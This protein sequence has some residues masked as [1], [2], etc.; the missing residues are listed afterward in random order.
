MTDIAKLGFEVDT[1]GLVRGKQATD[2]W[3]KSA[4][5]AKDTQ[6]KTAESTQELSAAF[7]KQQTLLQRQNILLTQGAEAAWKFD[8]EVEGL[9]AS[10][11]D[12]LEKLR[13]T[14]AEL[15]KGHEGTTGFA[16]ALGGLKGV[17]GAVGIAIASMGIDRV[18][19]FMVDSYRET[20]KMG[21]VLKTATG[22]VGLAAAELMKLRQYAADTPYTLAQ[23]VEGF[24]EL[25]NLG[26]DASIESM[27]SYGDTAS[28]LGKDYM[29]MVEAVADAATFQYDRLLEFGIKTQTEGDR[30]QFTFKGITTEVGKDSKAIEQYLIGLGK[31]EFSGAMSDQMDTLNG[32]ISN[33]QDA[34][35]EAANEFMVWSGAGEGLK[36][37]LGSLS[38]TMSGLTDAMRGARF[39][40]DAMSY[41][42]ADP[43]Q[44]NDIIGQVQAL[45]T[46]FKTA[47]DE[48]RVVIRAELL[49]FY[50]ELKARS[51]EYVTNITEE[52]KQLEWLP[53]MFSGA[54]A[55]M[56][57]ENGRKLAAT[58]TAINE[59][60]KAFRDTGTAITE[61]DEAQRPIWETMEAGAKRAAA[62]VA[63]V[64]AAYQ[65]GKA[66]WL[67]KTFQYS[68]EI[69]QAA[70]EFDVDPKLV[71]AVMKQESQGNLGAVSG[72]GATGLMQLMPET[73]AQVAKDLD[74]TGYSLLNA[75]D[76]IRL[77][78]AYLSQ[79]LV[80]Y[81]GNVEKALAAYNAG[82]GAVDKYGGVPPYDETQKYVSK[83]MA[84]YRGLTGEAQRSRDEQARAAKQ[85][86]D[87]EIREAKRSA[88]EQEREAKRVTA[89][90]EREAKK[91]ADAQQK[92]ADRVA[93]TLRQQDEANFQLS[94]QHA[95][96]LLQMRQ[97]L[98]RVGMSASDAQEGELRSQGYSPEEA[99][100]RVDVAQQITF[101]QTAQS[102]KEV[103]LQATMSADAFERW[104]LVH[105]DGLTPAMAE[106]VQAMKDQAQAAAEGRQLMDD[107]GN[108]IDQSLIGSLKSFVDTGNGL[109]D[110]MIA[111]LI[112]A[113]VT[114]ETLQKVF[115][116][117]GGGG[118][119]N[120]IVNGITS[121]FGF[122]GGGSFT[123]GGSGGT[124]S[125][126]VAF[127]A[128]P[129]EQVS[130][131]TPAQQAR[132]TPDVLG[133]AAVAVPSSASGSTRVNLTVNNQGSPVKAQAEVS[134][135]EN[136]LDIAVLL[137]AIDSHQAKG[138]RSGNSQT[139]DAISE[140]SGIRRSSY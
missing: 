33:L 128:T 13:R 116:S 38:A 26:L 114:S 65:K 85:A 71:Q 94:M 6:R 24:V 129:G 67:P 77:G 11:I 35:S 20:E 124:D 80:K 45:N 76:N 86:A 64:G 120:A 10:E 48:R 21:A 61:V 2:A 41:G 70:S 25:K 109:L 32:K 138:I 110:Q 102:I 95:V 53:E 131:A 93:D 34:A 22:S 30:V 49:D 7:Q 8:R 54:V 55:K 136:G 72:K 108:M 50:E 15:D 79:Q 19:G 59:V 100:A 115:N 69:N 106:S 139:W 3:E 118:V 51:A 63:S 78:V 90:K 4:D 43:G 107:W 88:D 74:M 56:A 132:A 81:D 140:V 31:T 14:N 75:S 44:F 122:S 60:K 87:K 133:I 135:G 126:L 117:Q 112:E 113:I 42:V 66:G 83:I 104:A 99:A 91:A 103:Y 18:A 89:D 58:E 84:D 46:E 47:S 111:K 137:E 29:Q 17:A 123:V 27:K 101:A 5:R 28:A 16:G 125:K 37:V 82:P 68:D 57:E 96:E 98:A 73:A 105:K 1:S 36:N 39:E 121:L 23:A 130:V 97:E 40:P 52:S 134:Q 12:L 127:M 92:E 119:G 9:T 62:A